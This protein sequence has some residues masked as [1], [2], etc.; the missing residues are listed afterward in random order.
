ME[1]FR[2]GIFLLL[3]LIVAVLTFSLTKSWRLYDSG[4]EV[5]VESTTENE[6]EKDKDAIAEPTNVIDLEDGNGKVFW[7]QFFVYP[8]GL[9]TEAGGFGPD[10]ITSHARNLFFVN[11]KNGNVKKLF[12][13]DVYVWDFV[14]G[15]FTKKVI[16]NNIDEPKE[17]SLNIERKMIIIA[18]REDSNKDGVLNHKDYKRIFLY[19]P[20]RETLDDIL[21]DGYVYR[22][23]IFNTQKNNLALVVRKLP[24]IV[25]EKVKSKKIEPQIQSEI[26]S[27]DIGLGKGILSATKN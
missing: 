1:K 15:E 10:G 6:N 22:K 2:I 3:L 5:S 12:S 4:Y 23:I 8:V 26:Y 7:K 9:V 14:I 18:A 24:E 20:D 27:Y 19:D 16:A 13:R 17:D 21:P 11:L 25:T